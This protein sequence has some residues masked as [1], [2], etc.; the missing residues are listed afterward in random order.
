MNPKLIAFTAAWGNGQTV[1]PASSSASASIPGNRN[2]SVLV[3]NL[4]DNICYARVTT[5]ASDSAST[6]DMPILSGNSFVIGK[7][8]TGAYIHYISADGTSLHVIPGDGI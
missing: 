4:G 7:P 5:N 8:E 1:S 6:A 2:R 3:T